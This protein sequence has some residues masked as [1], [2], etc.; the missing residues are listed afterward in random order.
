MLLGQ[1]AWSEVG[2]SMTPTLNSQGSKAEGAISVRYIGQR[3]RKTEVF[4]DVDG[5]LFCVS[6]VTVKLSK[7]KPE[8]CSIMKL[9]LL[10]HP[11][12]VTGIRQMTG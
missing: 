5:D 8:R 2:S 6:S 7:G 9:Q 10:R 12:S 1:R 3:A 11:K 4:G